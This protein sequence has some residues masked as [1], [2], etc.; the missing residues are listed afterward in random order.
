VGQA[1]L[2]HDVRHADAPETGATDGAR[3]G[4]DDAIVGDLL[5]A[6]G[7]AHGTIITHKYDDRHIFSNGQ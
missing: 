1:G 2:I 3:G 4:R 6:R 5:S 7:G